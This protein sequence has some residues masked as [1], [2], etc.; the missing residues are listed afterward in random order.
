[1]GKCLITDD[2]M[3]SVFFFF[4]PQ[5]VHLSHDPDKAYMWHLVAVQF[6]HSVVSDSLGPH[7]L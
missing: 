2:E 4:F 5:L 7:G 6:S 1:M 3:L